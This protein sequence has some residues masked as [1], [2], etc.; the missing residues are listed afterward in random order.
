MALTALVAPGGLGKTSLGIVEALAMATGR[1]I[2]GDQPHAPLR[3]WLV[4]L[5]DP[6]TR[7][8]G[9]LLRQPFTMAWSHPILKADC[10]ST[11][12]ASGRLSAAEQT[13]N[14]AVIVRPVIE[15]LEREIR[16][17]RIDVLILDPFVS[18]TTALPRTIMALPILSPRN[19]QP[20]PAGPTAPSNSS[21]MC[22][23]FGAR[24]RRR[25]MR[26]EAAPCWRRSAQPVF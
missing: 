24:K 15:A 9:A 25:K 20:S 14:G 21:T 17:N 19:G 3:V 18:S 2:V 23:S 6:A 10:I 16:A 12:V 1:S 4:N 7:W 22:G 26:E 11:S 5:E 13:R 8:N